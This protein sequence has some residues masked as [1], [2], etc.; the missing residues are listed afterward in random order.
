[1][2]IRLSFQGVDDQTLA[3]LL[4]CPTEDELWAEFREVS[5]DETHYF[6]L[7]K[8]WDIFH[9]LFTG[10]RTV[11]Y[12][13]KLILSRAITGRKPV[14]E[15]GNMTYLTRDQVKKLAML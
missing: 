4:A 2:G 1:M 5:Q 8:A 11:D 3:S 10:M 9:Y 13:T 6:S 15:S 7:G 14:D 12:P